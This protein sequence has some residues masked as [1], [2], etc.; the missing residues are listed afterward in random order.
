MELAVNRKE[1]KWINELKAA[2]VEPVDTCF[3]EEDEVPVCEHFAYK[4][5]LLFYAEDCRY[6]RYAQL[7]KGASGKPG[8]VCNCAK[9]Q[10][11][12]RVG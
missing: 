12:H 7:I 2:L 3:E 4:R 8:Y 5:T 6:C 1:V 10:S 9:A 11:E